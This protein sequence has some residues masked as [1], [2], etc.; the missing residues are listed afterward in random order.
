MS[1]K[2]EEKSVA[3]KETSISQRFI[4]KVSNEISSAIGAGVQL[5]DAQKRLATNLF[6]K[7]DNDLENAE[8]DRAKKN[9]NTPEI[10]WK[11]INMQKLALDAAHRIQLGLDALV[12]NHLHTI[13]YLNGKTGKYDLDLRIGYKG[14]HHYRT[15]FSSENVVDIRYEL[16][17]EGDNFK[18]LYR[19]VNTDVE[20]YIFES[21]DN[22]FE[23]GKVIG[24]FG[25]IMY[26]NPKKN[27][28]VLVS[29]EEFDKV[30]KAYTSGPVWKGDWEQ[31]MQL[32]TVVHRTTEQLDVDT[33]K[34][35]MSY[36]YVESQDSIFDDEIDPNKALEQ[37]KERE[38][39]DFDEETGEVM[40]GK[41]EK[42]PEKKSQPKPEPKDTKYLDDQ[43]KG[44]GLPFN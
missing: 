34:T 40:D 24:G 15:K 39:I 10:M 3:K 13:P 29:K 35:N 25:Y 30:K 41:P 6:V 26:E 7:L 9:K 16:V 11:N 36:H 14:K 23:R 5:T 33:T 8:A 31:R 19:D 21:A 38:E 1:K 44:E 28:I 43:V 27:K 4:T 42:K 17:H 18:P 32:K 2:K 37:P 12:P 20:T 22:P